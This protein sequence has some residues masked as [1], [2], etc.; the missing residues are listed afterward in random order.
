MD[1]EQVLNTKEF[2]ARRTLNRFTPPDG[3]RVGGSPSLGPLNGPAAQ[4][5]SSHRTALD[6]IT[7]RDQQSTPSI[8]PYSEA[9][10][11]T[12]ELDQSIESRSHPLPQQHKSLKRQRSPPPTSS[13]IS[14]LPVHPLSEPIV[15]S[16]EPRESIGRTKKYARLEPRYALRDER[17]EGANNMM[18][19]KLSEATHVYPK[20]ATGVTS[21]PSQQNNLEVQLHQRG[22][23]IH[24]PASFPGDF[25]Q[26][27]YVQQDRPEDKLPEYRQQSSLAH[28]HDSAS[29]SRDSTQATLG[30]WDNAYTLPPI[31]ILPPINPLPPIRTL[32]ESRQYYS[33]PTGYDPW[34]WQQHYHHGRNHDIT[35]E[36]SCVNKYGTYE[37]HIMESRRFIY[38][39]NGER[40]LVHE[41][42]P[43]GPPLKP[44]DP[45]II[46]SIALRQ[47]LYVL[48]K[49]EAD[50]YP[51]ADIYQ[52]PLGTKDS[53]TLI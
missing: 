24:Q 3:G 20:A 27:A 23:T 17:S 5:G 16:D 13:S 51:V 18:A 19:L 39:P 44:F 4:P 22:E 37:P 31:N 30:H 21:A 14:V 48:R 1:L 9:L 41:T 45:P 11:N 12:H 7:R 33:T 53:N 6:I 25:R 47:Q 32:S 29:S 49:Q 38:E 52:V 2:L 42:S 35:H 26:G 43:M 36:H 28:T 34:R 8:T 40:T 50:A 10:D 46:E 15:Q